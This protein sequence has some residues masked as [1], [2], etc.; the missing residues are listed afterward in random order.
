VCPSRSRPGFSHSTR[1]C[2]LHPMERRLHVSYYFFLEPTPENGP[3][4]ALSVTI[5]FLFFRVRVCAKLQQVNLG[6]GLASA[7][8]IFIL[9]WDGFVM[10]HRAC[11][12]AC[13][14]SPYSVPCKPL[15]IVIPNERNRKHKVANC[16]SKGQGGGGG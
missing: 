4:R 10:V 15:R 14:Q 7:I 6:N 16:P 12:C 9:S 8:V 13:H 5:T 1:T 2:A 3:N 11:Q